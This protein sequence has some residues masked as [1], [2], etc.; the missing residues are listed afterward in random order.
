MAKVLIVGAGRVGLAAAKI[1]RFTS[2]HDVVLVDAYQEAL[3]RATSELAGVPAAATSGSIS[4]HVAG[5]RDALEKVMTTERPAVVICSTPFTIN[6]QVAQ[7]AAKHGIHYLD[8]TEDN[9]VTRE[10]IGLGISRLTFVPQTGLAPGL[11]SYIGLELFETLGVPSTL[12]LRVG[13]LPQV[14]FGPAYYA[15][16]WSPEGLINEY[17]KP[18]LRKRNHIIE[19]VQP[20]DEQ[21]ELLVDGTIYEGFTT[22]GGVGNLDAYA[23]IP[24]V[25][26]KTLR[27]PGHLEFIQKLL[28]RVN[29]DLDDG[30]KAAKDTF[31]RTRDDVVV[32]MAMAIDQD[33]MMA[34]AGMHFMPHDRLRLTALELTTAGTGV[35][36]MELI[37]AGELPAG[38]LKPNQIPMAAIRRTQAYEL[39][40]SAV[41]Q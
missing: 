27:H 2:E 11:V 24:N 19:A 39:I 38:V 25:E 8:F 40:F 15:I 1:I 23:D 31:P 3:N 29:Y 32:L 18:A 10:I 17:L 6:I 13:A 33:N 34:T 16:T 20:L 41:R 22:S 35:A 12:N 21:E 36:V 7:L 4:M 9:D 26:Y 5:G 30:V 37:L 14:A 28:S